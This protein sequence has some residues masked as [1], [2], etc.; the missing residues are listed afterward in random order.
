MSARSAASVAAFALAASATAFAAEEDPAKPVSSVGFGLGYVDRD[1]PRFGQYNG[2]HEQGGY[3]LLDVY[4][5]KRDDATGTWTKL[6]G[7]NLGLESR[8]LR[9]EQNR[10]GNWGYFIEYGRTP[11]IEPYTVTTAVSGIGTGS[12]SVPGTPTTGSTYELKTKRDVI[13]LGFD[14]FFL[15]AWDVQVRFRN[16]EKDGARIFARGTTGTLAGFP[17]NFEFTP[18]PINSTTRQ[19]DVIVG[20]T[21]EKLQLSGGYYGTMYNN[22]I[23][24][25]YI[26]GGVP[27]LATPASTAF[28]PIALPPDNSSHQLHLSGGYSFTPTTRASFKLAHTNAKQDDA[29]LATPGQARSALIGPNLDAKVV[30]TLAQAGIVSRPMPKLT[31]RADLRSEDRDDKTPVRQY[32]TPPAPGSTTTATGENEP[33]SIRTT[34]AMAEAS[35]LLPYQLRITG[36]IENEEKKRNTS[37]VRIVSHRDTTEEL[38]YRIELRRSMSETFTGAIQYVHS[39]RDGSAFQTTTVFNGTAGSNLI[40]PLHLADRERD[41]IRF[42]SNWTPLEPLSIQFFVD[43][44]DDKYS[45]RDGSGL[46]PRNGKAQNYSL[47]AGYRFSDKWQGNVW[48]NRNDTRAEQVTCEGTTGPACT[49]GATNPI[50]SAKLRSKSDSFG[51][52][53]RGQPN[54]RLLIGGDL[55]YSI[56]KDSYLQQSITPP[57]STDAANLPEISTRL[58]RFNLYAKY[59]L[60]KHSSVRVDYIYDRYKTNDW[61]WTN[62]TFADGT[63]VNENPNQRVNYLGASYIYRW[64]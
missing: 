43:Y 1:G 2:M 34:R 35:Y 54:D 58:T 51:L 59:M 3:G 20:Y 30:T 24:G 55:H 64:Q 12:I 11:R 26:T 32:F 6:Q 15:N 62:F 16:E 36:G 52:G 8:Q 33:R 37:A 56:I 57:T 31:L 46:G 29:F 61:T 22:K 40:A 21:G 60:E 23:N 4:L 63:T 17:G 25:L 49:A 39:D 48:F 5:N 19:L 45:G 9:F 7:R 27:A 10:Q 44:A 41:K 28:T 38:S 18:E 14:K 53:F 13:G 50:Y 42:T 47:D